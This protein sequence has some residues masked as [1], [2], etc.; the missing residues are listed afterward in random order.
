MIH[1][2]TQLSWINASVG[3]GVV[4]TAPIPKGTILWTRCAFDIVLSPAKV[5]ALS[6]PYHQ[7]ASTYG[8]LDQNGDTILCWDLGRYVNHACRPTMMSLG[9]DIELCVTDL[10]P[11]DELT[12][13]YGVLN[14]P[15]FSCGCGLPDCRGRITAKDCFAYGDP[16]RERLLEAM[17]CAHHV[18]QPLLPYLLDRKAWDTLL[19]GQSVIPDPSDYYCQPSGV[20][21]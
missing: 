3:R 2:D 6:Q 7:I 15:D 20:S 8:Y 13:D 12:C 19:A 1:P 18:E 5:Q 17:A 14:Y 21:R 10:Q 4:A 11:G 16:W 9:Y